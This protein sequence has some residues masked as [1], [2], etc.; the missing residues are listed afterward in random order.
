MDM[1]AQRNEKQKKK[2]KKQLNSIIN[3]KQRLIK[4]VNENY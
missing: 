3:F 1:K 2:N 4:R